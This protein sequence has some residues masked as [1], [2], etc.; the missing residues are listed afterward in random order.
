MATKVDSAELG[1]NTSQEADRAGATPIAAPAP[2]FREIFDALA[3]YVWRTL[4]RLGVR[5]ADVDDMCQ[6]VF[7]VVH[8]RLGDFSGTSSVRTW[9]YGIALRVAS[10]HRRGARNRRE[11]LTLHLPEAS[12]PPL[13]EDAVHQE[14]LLG[15]LGRA[16]NLLDEHRRDVFVLYELEEMTMKEVAEVLGCPLQTAYSRLHAARAVV[17][18]AFAEGGSTNGREKDPSP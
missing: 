18:E 16:L 14:Q 17:R 9:V 3:P 13:Q 4:R 11:D 5:D 1:T 8:R 15:R 10:Q 6:E 7:V 2:H 12:L